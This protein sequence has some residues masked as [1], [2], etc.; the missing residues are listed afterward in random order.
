M[1]IVATA[2]R[3][4]EFLRIPQMVDAL[5]KERDFTSKGIP[6]ACTGARWEDKVMVV[7]VEPVGERRST[8][9]D[10]GLEGCRAVWG[11]GLENRGEIFLVNADNGELVLRFVK[12]TLPAA[13]DRVLLYQRDFLSPL[14]DL[15]RIPDRAEKAIKA[16]HRSEPKQVYPDKPLPSCFAELRDRQKAAVLA[17]LCKQALIIGPPGTGKTFTTGALIAYLLTRFKNSRLLLVGPTNVAVDT[18]LHAAD[19]WL[20]RLGK[21]ALRQ[22]LKRIGSRF[23]TRK[24]GDRS[25]LLAPGIADAALRVAM[26]EI[27]EPSRHD[28]AKYVDWKER[29]DRARA[30]LKTDVL[31][32]ARSARL[33]GITTSSLFIWNELISAAGPW[34]F[35]VCDEASQVF[36]PAALM[37]TTFALQSTFAGDPHQLSPVVQSKSI[38]VRK[39]LSLTAFQVVRGA[40]TVQLN[41]QSR[42]SHAI[43]DA[44]GSTFYGGDLMVCRKAQKDKAWKRVRSPYFVNGREVPRLMFDSRADDSTWSRK[45]N[46]LIRFSSAKLASAYAAEFLGSYAE[47]KDVLILTPFRAQRALIRTFLKSG[48]LREVRVGTVHKS[49][50]SESKIVIF[51]P[52]DA[53]ASFLNSEGGKRL[54]NVALSRAQA[55]AIF[56]VNHG[57]LQN[58]WLRKLHTRSAALWHTKGDYA[59]PFFVKAPS[60]VV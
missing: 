4:E 2:P 53:S 1:P 18:A 60:G 11:A 33:I 13:G 10:D 35:T 42:M 41:E 44:V 22:S 37:L 34:H 19:D 48:S 14:L 45:Y 59:S 23:D 38:E 39:V 58:P 15:W 57:D 52:V 25:H 24:Y 50:G 36:A 47:A 54:I 6:F 9:I 8:A 20:K 31:T 29:L 40:K 17:S 56:I 46:G 7:I 5:Q 16:A 49:Q 43:C 55:H 32:I 51:D 12:G 26:L 21:T 28:L 3:L 30:E 27:E